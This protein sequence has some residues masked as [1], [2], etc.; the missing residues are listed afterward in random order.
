MSRQQALREFLTHLGFVDHDPIQ[1]DLI[2]QA[3]THPSL[4]QQTN[5]NHLEFLGDAVLRIL[6]TELLYT[7][8]RNRP[9]GELSSLRSHLVSDAYLSK[10]ADLWGF[11]SVILMGM[12]AHQDPRGRNRRLADAFEAVLGAL[13]L[14]WKEDPDK[15]KLMRQWLIPQFNQRISE[16][17]ED[18]TRNNAKA[19]LQELTQSL[20]GELPTYKV[21]GSQDHPPHFQIEVWSHGEC[22]GWGEGSS[23]KAAETAAA[24]QAYFR[25]RSTV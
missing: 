14:C 10:L 20:W 24:Q 1:W 5:Y 16:I 13:Y 12:S 21:V 2:D 22:W 3:L 6:V 11:D 19:A 7:D 18:P 23:K 25:I 9:V 15:I 17:L 8:H 4:S